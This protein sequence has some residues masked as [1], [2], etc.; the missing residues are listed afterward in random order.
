M[1]IKQKLLSTKLTVVSANGT[2]RLQVNDVLNFKRSS[3]S[4]WISYNRESE[5]NQD[6]EY[7]V[8]ADS[9]CLVVK[10]WS[11]P[12]E[13]EEKPEREQTLFILASD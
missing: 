1:A 5:P 13:E 7:L 11:E 3:T 2:L 10:Q 9:S 4:N 6:F 8:P 12:V